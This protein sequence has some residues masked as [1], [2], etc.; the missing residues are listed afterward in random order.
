[1]NKNENF[2]TNKT[3]RFSSFESID[4][5]YGN[6]DT[7]DRIVSTFGKFRKLKMMR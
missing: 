7:E 5:S 4:L 6:E 2:H 3:V 1:M